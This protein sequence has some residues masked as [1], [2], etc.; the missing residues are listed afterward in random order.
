MFL[1]YYSDDFDRL[2]VGSGDDKKDKL[3][4]HT[5]SSVFPVIR[6]FLTNNNLD[7]NSEQS[8]D[9]FEK[10][11]RYLNKS[12]ETEIPKQSYATLCLQKDKR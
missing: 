8:R 11:C 12:M 1:Y 10:L 7:K 5:S 4:L 2:I 6:R 3:I 9:R